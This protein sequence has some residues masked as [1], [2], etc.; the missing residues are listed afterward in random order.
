MS[1]RIRRDCSVAQLLS[2]PLVVNPPHLLS[3]DAPASNPTRC[4]N[5]LS[6]CR[7]LG[8][9]A[10]NWSLSAAPRLGSLAARYLQRFQERRL[11]GGLHC[12]GGVRSQQC[13]LSRG[14][15]PPTRARRCLV[16]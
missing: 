8:A 10:Q 11:G 15:L 1:I 16:Q 12:E 13:T 4:V 5:C 14:S 9:Y 6:A 2:L 7:V 3:A